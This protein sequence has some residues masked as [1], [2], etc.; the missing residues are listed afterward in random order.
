MKTLFKINKQFIQKRK[1]QCMIYYKCTIQMEIMAC[2]YMY[3]YT[4]ICLYI[5]TEIYIYFL[6]K[7]I[8]K[9]I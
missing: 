9:I 6:H 2:M 3:V 4:L 1:I 5:Y 7:K 8:N